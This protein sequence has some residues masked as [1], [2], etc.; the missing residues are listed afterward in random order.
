MAIW[1]LG[2]GMY[3]GVGSGVSRL[4]ENFTKSTFRC[5]SLL[6]IRTLAFISDVRFLRWLFVPAV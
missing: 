6:S 1:R 4:L 2:V 3:A 5:L